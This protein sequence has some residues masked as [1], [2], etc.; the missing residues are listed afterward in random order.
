MTPYVDGCGAILFENGKP[1]RERA[2]DGRRRCRSHHDTSC[3]CCGE[4]DDPNGPG[5]AINTGF[6]ADCTE[7]G[8]REITVGSPCAADTA[9]G[10]AATP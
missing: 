2:E 7:A 9:R 10:L 1:C 4:V 6:C 3:W 5:P 8:C